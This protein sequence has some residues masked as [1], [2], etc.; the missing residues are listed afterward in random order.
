MILKK[1]IPLLFVIITFT[2]IFIYYPS[3]HKHHSFKI[4]GLMATEID[5]QIIAPDNLNVEKIKSGLIDE[6]R[7][8]EKIFSSYD[9]ES[10]LSQVNQK[11]FE[12]DILLSK[13]LYSVIKTSITYGQLSN[14][15]FDMTILP[16]IR[17]WK[18]TNKSSFKV[19]SDKQIKDTLKLIDYRNIKL[20][21]GKLS[22]LKKGMAIGLGGIAK[23]YIIDRGI[24]YL[25]EQ[26]IENALL[27]IGGDL[28]ALGRKGNKDKWKVAIKNPRQ[29]QYNTPNIAVILLENQA[30]ATSGDYERFQISK[31]GKRAHH[32]L[33][34][35]TGYPAMK[36][37]SVTILAPDSIMADTIAT[38]VFILGPKEGLAF[39][40][41][42]Q[43]VEGMILYEKAGQIKSVISSKFPFRPY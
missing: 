17:L 7:R 42:N 4:T 27:N 38:I 32:I 40:E 25:K 39:I 41:K 22:F 28:Y 13:D 11:A 43:N 33:N 15:A 20:N 34:P 18:V 8:L 36:S 9:P 2:I 10:E 5:L 31:S 16:L 12:K 6:L 1:I 21:N 19:P 30:L 24:V 14:G 23:G 35:K 3:H 26:G 29:G 37:I